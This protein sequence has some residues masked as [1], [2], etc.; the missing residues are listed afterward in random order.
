MARCP[1]SC[2]LE[3]IVFESFAPG[4]LIGVNRY[5]PKPMGP[6]ISDRRAQKS[7]LENGPPLESSGTMRW[8]PSAPKPLPQP[9]PPTAPYHQASQYQDPKQNTKG[10]GFQRE[11]GGS[12]EITEINEITKE[13]K[14]KSMILRPPPKPHFPRHH[15]RLT[16]ATPSLMYLFCTPELPELW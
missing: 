6:P 14:G 16:V 11:R 10:K 3:K 7:N 13:Y 8:R 4:E 5:P 2:I 9:S 12:L 1:C 15:R